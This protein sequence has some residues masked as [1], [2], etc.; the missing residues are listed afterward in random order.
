MFL[1]VNIMKKLKGFTLVELIIVIAI[2]G[3][4]AAVLTPNMMNCYSEILFLN[5][6]YNSSY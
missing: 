5:L 4:L 2:I 1:G 6:R 3:I